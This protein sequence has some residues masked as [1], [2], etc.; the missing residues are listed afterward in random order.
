MEPQIVRYSVRPEL[1]DGIND[2]ASEVWPEYNLHGEATNRYWAQ[3]F[4]VFPDWQFVLYGAGEQVVL[5]EGNTI[6][7][8][9]DGADAGLRPGINATLAAA[10]ELH[11]SAGS[12]PLPARC[13]QDDPVAA[14][15]PAPVWRCAHGDGGPRPAPRPLAVRL[16]SR[17][18]KAPSADRRHS[19]PEQSL[20]PRSV[21]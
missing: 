5:A 12:P 14:P 15:G 1:W 6:P 3:L 21:P 7:V 13:R 18:E 11:A 17:P 4:D 9:W 19:S 16:L 8:A 20:H 10:F 2:L